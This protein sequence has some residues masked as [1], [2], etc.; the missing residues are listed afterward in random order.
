MTALLLAVS[1][2][3][4]VTGAL[5]F[6]NAV[7]WLGQRLD[8]GQGAVGSVLAAVGTALPESTIPVIAVLAGSEGQDVAIGAIVGAPF[9]LATVA[10]LLI[11]GSA[12]VFRGRRSSG[13]EV[14]ADR[15]TARRDIGFF[16]PSLAAGLALG[17]ID[18][19]ALHY[20]GAAVLVGV[21]VLY[22]RRTLRA[23]SGADEEDEL[24]ALTFDASKDDPPS[25]LQIAAQG[26]VALALIIG[27]AE[28]FVQGITKVA[29][30]VGVP[31]LVLALIIAP[32][33]TELPE[34]IN[35]VIWMRKDKDQL[36]V[37]NVTGALA[38]QSTI[39][40]ALGLAVTDWQLNRFATAAGVLALIGGAL[41]LW[42][43]QRR[44]MGVPAALA[45]AALFG[46][47]IAFV[48]VG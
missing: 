1:F 19:K 14:T 5:L 10:M 33:A 26:L 7:E 48:A 9:M 36:A 35:S 12:L 2:A 34:K 29:E 4:I 22:V 25:T 38:F 42:R 30:S 18:A 37:G 28:L 45:W 41:A 21:Y 15:A 24:K 3:L 43:L 20:A 44:S 39:P 46:A 8:M 47:L 6:T 23:G 32:L 27:G 40:V 16:L 11:A 17:Q 31:T 13:T